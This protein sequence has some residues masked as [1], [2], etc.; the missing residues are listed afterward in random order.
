MNNID[1]MNKKVFANSYM[2]GRFY[3]LVSR[4]EVVTLYHDV[5]PID[6]DTRVFP[7]CVSSTIQWDFEVGRGVIHEIDAVDALNRGV[8]SLWLGD[9]PELQWTL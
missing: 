5:Y 6:G 4:G 8:P 2:P 7:N 3:V 9:S 1:R